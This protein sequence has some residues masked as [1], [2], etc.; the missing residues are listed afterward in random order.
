MAKEIPYFKFYTG[1]WFTGDIVLEDYE[2]QGLFINICAFYWSKDC[3]LSTVMLLKKFK[4][5]DKHL[6]QLIEA[7]LI[8]TDGVN[9]FISFLD[10]QFDSKEVQ[11]I[12]NRVNGSKGGRP[13][14]PVEQKPNGFNL[15]SELKT[16]TK[17]NDNPQHNPNITNIKE[18]KVDYSKE[19]ESKEED[20][21]FTEKKEELI[22]SLIEVFGFS[23]HKFS[24][25]KSMVFSFVNS[26]LKSIED[27][28]HFAEQYKNYDEYKKLSGEQRH[29]STG[30]F[31]TQAMQFQ[32]AAWNSENWGMKL[33][34]L[35][36]SK[37]PSSKLDNLND[38]FGKV[39]QDLYNGNT[40]I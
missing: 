40:T 18:S 36:Q 7:S 9:I 2:T 10:E 25:Q 12:T 15:G 30:Y 23:E 35:K 33:D 11:K 37:K 26:Q 1:E 3:E 16:Q 14:K 27:I 39:A 8:K 17:P 29:N 38:V 6:Y 31:G 24:Q 22:K 19:E 34:N 4:G 28:M 20:F 21:A 5:Y 32:N 13:R